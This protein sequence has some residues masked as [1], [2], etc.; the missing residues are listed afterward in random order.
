M[1][2]KTTRISTLLFL[3]ALL[4]SCTSP[5]GLRTTNYSETSSE[6]QPKYLFLF[7][8]DG[9]GMAQRTLTEYYKNRVLEDPTPLAMHTLPVAA[10]ITTHSSSSIIT[11][12]AAAGTALSSGYKTYNGAIGVDNSK[13]SQDTILEGLQ[14]EGFA[15]GLITTTRI[16]HATPAS[17]ASHQP[18][19]SMENEIAEDYIITGVDFLAG[20]GYRHFVGTDS[21]LPTKRKD[22][23]LLKDYQQAGYRTYISEAATNTFLQD[24]ITQADKILGLFA[25]SHIPYVIDRDEPE[26]TGKTYPTLAQMTDKGIDFFYNKGKDTG[27]FLMV[28][29]GRI[30]H[31][32]HANDPM[33]VVQE[34]LEF[35][36][37]LSKALAFYEKHPEETLIIVTADHETGGL[38]LG[39]RLNDYT[40]EGSSTQEYQLYPENIVGNHSLED[41]VGSKFRELDQDRKAFISYLQTEYGLGELSGKEYA[42]LEQ[43]MN[44]ESDNNPNNDY[45]IY[46]SKTSLA[47]SKIVALRANVNWS[48]ELHT[49]IRIPLGAIG[50]GAH[51]FSGYFDNSEVPIR[52]AQL[53]GVTTPMIY[54]HTCENDLVPAVERFAQERRSTSFIE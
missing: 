50:A 53:V 23:G 15:T 18:R 52:M 29:G 2:K 24:D 19:R 3:L 7:I 37:A 47:V 6:S 14:A 32:S 4:W 1:N 20:G 8:G 16:T 21:Q 31:A 33:G 42:I 34:T 49:A 11:D 28:E 45:G 46:Y 35:D 44:D 30:D 22:L 13:R 48:T 36:K 27:F 54:A 40:L 5:T 26:S 41:V 9:M 10:D 38:S 12:S 51:T 25:P 43:A 39:G 17:F